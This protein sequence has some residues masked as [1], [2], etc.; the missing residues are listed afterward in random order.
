MKQVLPS[1][2]ISS[3]IVSNTVGGGG[4]GI[5]ANFRRSKAELGEA[6][7]GGGGAAQETEGLRWKAFVGG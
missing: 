5:F 7:R 2:Q 6:E 1:P 3:W 4:G